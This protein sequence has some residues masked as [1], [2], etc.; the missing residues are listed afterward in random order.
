MS[1][2]VLKQWREDVQAGETVAAGDHGLTEIDVEF[3]LAAGFLENVSSEQEQP[4]KLKNSK[5]K[6]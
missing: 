1:F 4:A 6:D 5:R 2:L 3:L